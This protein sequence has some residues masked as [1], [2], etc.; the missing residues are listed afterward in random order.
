V[1]AT[2]KD[3]RNVR[4]SR[5]ELEFAPRQTYALESTYSMTTPLVLDLNLATPLYGYE[6]MSASFRHNMR[7]AGMDTSALVG[8]LIMAL[9]FATKKSPFL[10]ILTKMCACV[11]KLAKSAF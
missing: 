7:D 9:V 5:V 11:I 10:I 1:L 4:Q 2:S 3:K 8:I 6:A